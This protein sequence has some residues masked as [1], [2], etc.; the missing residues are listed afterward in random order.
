MNAVDVKGVRLATFDPNARG[1]F[2]VICVRFLH[3][4]LVFGFVAQTIW[5][6]AKISDFRR[7]AIGVIN[8][9]AA[10]HKHMHIGGFKM[11]YHDAQHAGSYAITLNIKIMS[12]LWGFISPR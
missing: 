2:W 7:Y 1:S 9:E 8:D 5:M 10:E 3:W 12:F 11:H 6:A 4:L